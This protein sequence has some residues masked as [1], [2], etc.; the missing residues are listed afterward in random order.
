MITLKRLTL[1]LV[2]LLG[3]SLQAQLPVDLTT[4]LTKFLVDLRAGTLGINQVISTITATGN[5]TGSSIVAAAAGTNSFLGRSFFSSTANG[6]LRFGQNSGAVG[7]L[8]EMNMGTANP[9]VTSCGTGTVTA[10]STNTAGEVT[11][12]GASACTL[13]FGTPAYT[14]KPFCVVTMETVAEVFR[15]SAISTTAFTVTF[16]T[17]ANVFSYHCFG[18]Q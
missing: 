11:P 13:T 6:L 12:T 15:I 16:T 10:N 5:I 4:Q 8:L 17:A 1:I 3:V 2:C 18:G 9:T 14:N 7:T